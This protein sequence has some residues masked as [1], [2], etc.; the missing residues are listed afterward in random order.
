MIFHELSKIR[1]KRIWTARVQLCHQKYDRLIMLLN[2]LFSRSKRFVIPPTPSGNNGYHD[3][4]LFSPMGVAEVAKVAEPVT[5]AQP[6]PLT[7]ANRDQGKVNASEK[8]NKMNE[9]RKGDLRRKSVDQNQPIV[10]KTVKNG[11]TIVD[12]KAREQKSEKLGSQR[13]RKELDKIMKD[14]ALKVLPALFS[15][16]DIR[17]STKPGSRVDKPKEQRTDKSNGE[18]VSISPTF[19]KQLFRTKVF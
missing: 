5:V 12:V 18:Q 9:M 17:Y 2:L 8:G 1:Q 19:D 16:P 3:D 14:R 6:Q 4:M 15:S 7:C 10:D 11:K 13:S